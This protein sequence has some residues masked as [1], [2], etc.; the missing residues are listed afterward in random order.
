M[1]HPARVVRQQICAILVVVG[2]AAAARAAAGDAAPAVP[3]ADN[4][5]GLADVYW[6]PVP[7]D[8][9]YAYPAP[10]GRVWRVVQP[11]VPPGRPAATAKS[12][13]DVK[14][15]I[16]TGFADATLRGWAATPVLFEPGGR[17]WVTNP[18]RS[19]L[20]GYDGRTWVEKALAPDAHLSGS[21]VAGVKAYWADNIHFDGR[22]FFACG[23]AGPGG[24]AG[25]VW[26][27]GNEWAYQHFGPAKL[28]P[29]LLVEPGGK[30]MLAVMAGGGIWRRADGRWADL[31]VA[32][33]VSADG[34]TSVAV[35]GTGLWL[36]TGDG[37][38]VFQDLSDKPPAGLAGLVAR[39]GAA[40]AAAR[41]R[42][43][44]EIRALGP[45]AAPHLRAA[46]EVAADSPEIQRRLDAILKDLGNVP[47]PPYSFGAYAITK[48]YSLCDLPD[49]T[50]C[51]AG[52]G[53]VSRGQDVGPGAILLAPNG[54]SKLLAGPE[55]AYGWQA[56]G[57]GRF[58][59]AGDGAKDEKDGERAGRRVW[60]TGSWWGPNSG[61]TYWPARLVDLDKGEVVATAPD[62]GSNIPYASAADGTLLLGRMERGSTPVM[63]FKPGAKD[64]RT[65]IEVS[66]HIDCSKPP[67][68]NSHAIAPD[69]DV[70]AATTGGPV[71]FDGGAFVLPAAVG[72]RG[73][74]NPVRAA[75]GGRAL[76][77]RPG[78]AQALAD[79]GALLE[80][81]AS[82]AEGPITNHTKAFAAAFPA[83]DGFLA[84]Y[85]GEG[86]G[87]AAGNVW[88]IYGHL[89]TPAGRLKIMDA[90]DRVAP[91]PAPPAPPP[92][93]PGGVPRPAPGAFPRHPAVLCDVGNGRKVFL[94]VSDPLPW[95]RGEDRTGY[96]AFLAEVKDGK[97]DL[98]PLPDVDGATGALYRNVHEPGGALWMSGPPKKVK[99]AGGGEATVSRS[100]RITPDGAEEVL[101][102]GTAWFTDAGG[103][104]FLADNP[105]WGPDDGRLKL[106]RA[107]KVVGDLFM[108]GAGGGM[109]TY[110]DR[111]GSLWAATGRGV[112]HWTADDPNEPGGA[113]GYKRRAVY[114]VPGVRGNALVGFSSKGFLVYQDYARRED[115][116]FGW[117]MHLAPF[118]K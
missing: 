14:A 32:A 97:I 28:G 3:G 112:E 56:L 37:M 111:P 57:G 21:G 6:Q 67:V 73:D 11:H 98:T 33:A 24:W 1:T 70:W 31:G 2:L 40:G 45:Q 35:A 92:P 43:A 77:V 91:P 36:L 115:G 48:P 104:V 81:G 50:V 49:G 101:D 23:R 27:D 78:G 8:V 9:V 17:L 93:A 113:N 20:L 114:V 65:P 96:H 13:A 52:D 82:D 106:W 29:R 110:S 86:V 102:A 53:V 76:L 38:L 5:L 105:T 51:A 71:R 39:L 34:R 117:R 94:V 41:D 60:L 74:W 63:A 30:S 42:A 25:V 116:Q 103:T 46:K 19:G 22:A 26:Y 59:W 99:A 72:G 107:G 55:F 12:A 69:G 47:K 16:E 10:G 85:G 90:V 118:P 58:L 83:A 64:D 87:D 108:E 54:T 15:D 61:L 66:H 62:F 18:G 89:H 79:G 109:H 95:P 80:G 7:G 75:R 100:Y 88:T 68:P 44:T 4:G 84:R